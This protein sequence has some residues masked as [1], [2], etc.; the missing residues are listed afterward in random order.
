VQEFAFA[1]LR[2]AITFTKTR[3]RTVPRI[4][5]CLSELAID[6][7]ICSDG[8][9]P[10]GALDSA[11][12]EAAREPDP[13]ERD[14]RYMGHAA[15]L[16]VSADLRPDKSALPHNILRSAGHEAIP[17]SFTQEQIWLHAQLLPGIPIYNETVTIHR[18]GTLDAPSLAHSLTEIVR[19]HPVWRTNFALVNG[20]P[21]QVIQPITPANL[22]VVDV[23]DIPFS[24]REAAALRLAKEAAMRPFDLHRDTLFRALL[25]HFSETEHRL[26]LTLHH[27]I[28]DEYSI[29][30]VFLPELAAIYSKISAGERPTTGG[31]PLGYAD[32]AIWQRTVFTH[33]PRLPSQLE[34]WR[35]QLAGDLPVLQLPSDH[36]RPPISSFHGAT[37]P[38]S[39][40]P[41]LGQ[42]LK[43]LSRREGATLFMTLLA[44][45]AV[46]LQRYS[47]S[48]D[49]TVGTLSSGR[50][51]T[52]LE[53]LLG[54]FINPVALRIDLT[55]EPTFREV[56]RRVRRVTLE[57]LSNDDVPFTQ[58]ANQV[59]SNH[60]LGSNPLFQVLFTLVPPA[61]DTPAGWNVSFTQLEVHSGTSRF[62]LSLE[63]DDR[64][65][66]IVGRFR[67]RTDLF[68]DQRIA[69]MKGH[70]ATL[71]DSIVANPDQRI[72]KLGFLTPPE[73]QQIHS[74]NS[75]AV[76]CPTDQV[77]HH[78]FS[79]QAER[80]PEAAALVVGSEQ[81]TYRELDAKSNQLAAHLR[82]RGIG[83][84]KP[85]GLYLESSVEMIVGTMG[86]LKAGGA[87]VPL[88][89]SY[90]A[91]RLS[92]AIKDTRL[93]LV[94]TRERL[95]SQLPDSGAEVLCLDS[96]REHLE[97]LSAEP[98]PSSITAENLAYLIYTSGSTG[99]PKGVQIAH[100][101]LVHSTH[102]RSLYYGPDAARFLLLSS[103]S[104]DSS[105]AGI[106]GTLCQGGTLVL[107]PGPVKANL[108]R[109]SSL[110]RE[111][112][113][114]RLL[115]VPSLYALI[116]EQAKAGELASLKE[117]IV[118]GE[119]CSPELVESH[120]KVVPQAT[121]FNEYGPTEAAVWSTVYKCCSRNFDKLVPIGRPIPNARV[122]VLDSDLN[123]L[124]VGIPGELYIGGPGVV[125]GYLN[126][127][128]DTAKSF[129]PDPFSDAP[130]PR[131]YK[132]GDVTRYLPDG[133]LELLGRLDHQVKIRG[134][135]IELEEVES[136]LG[137]YDGVRQAAVAVR[138]TNGTEPM[139]VAYVV[140]KNALNFAGGELRRFLAGKL[141]EAII[142]SRFVTLESLP[143]MPNGKVNRHA[144]STLAIDIE[145]TKVVP[146]KDDLES[147]LVEVWSALFNKPEIGVTESFFDLGGNS[148]LVAKLLLRVE[149]QFKKRLS[150]AEVFQC[151]TIRQMAGLLAPEKQRR[152]HPAVVPLQPQGSRTPLY[153]IDGGPL[154]L[155]LARSFD[156]DQPVIGLRVPV[157]EAGRFHVPF[158][159]EDGARELVRYLRELQPAGPYYLA[160]LCID[161]LVAYEMARQLISEGQEVALL[162]LFDVPSPSPKQVSS[163][164]H[165]QERQ[166]TK[167]RMLWS[168]LLRGGIG[169]IPKFIHLRG[170]AIARRFKLLRWNIQQSLGL[171]LNLNK[172]LNDPDAVEEPASYLSKPRPYAGHV[173]FFQSDEWQHSYEAWENLISGGWEVHRVA[174]GHVSMFHEKQ[175]AISLAAKLQAC[176]S[177]CQ[178]EKA[179][180]DQ[181]H[182]SHRIPRASD[183]AGHSS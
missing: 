41:K 85:V 148:L 176:L 157:S 150:L 88:D 180:T 71:L 89:P 124:P 1:K 64:P 172:I 5:S 109:L 105:L 126:R 158:R 3:I 14:M 12:A 19:R 94:I 81:L 56:L 7:R 111:H 16:N 95:R 72:S 106:L 57:A 149:Q 51:R 182:R 54:C 174:G 45:F 13:P 36:A 68:D 26:F 145:V 39:L 183:S 28:C 76:D 91:E 80:T 163:A 110:I 11:F 61:P 165:A 113:I 119:S 32:F 161:A 167:A 128:A 15:E 123:L 34:Y 159:L 129:V 33:D 138:Q 144:L 74:W 4:M 20:E 82:R 52:E 179:R 48:S 47:S 118:G 155:P 75:T 59:G 160:G 18:E 6:R 170:N 137:E 175:N 151:P 90:P 99:K 117:A 93:E 107:T 141:P 50:K 63:L 69:R 121:L 164:D 42:S 97:Q 22:Q 9:A 86:V 21:V 153:W 100:R 46:L 146:P 30:R 166:P 134:F 168:E 31:P 162:A 169:G 73:E 171:K 43:Q 25:V 8:I 87:C 77:L 104:F 40:E 156:K 62:D 24:Q 37:E 53:N 78:V 152:S 114:T 143:L 70:L 178:T 67:Y 35:K 44:G 108:Q 98:V 122:F 66:G 2:C 130:G 96:E 103:F 38:I 142:P 181:R 173:T 27:I 125:R 17:L 92:Y 133:N 147:A 83:P 23:S 58:V 10:A 60:T 84:E 135:R 65:D 29:S 102:A 101:N 140:P 154:F 49:L 116:L 112:Q 177:E 120:Y 79:R 132:T 55:G 131:L 115:C 139:L 136:V 127:P